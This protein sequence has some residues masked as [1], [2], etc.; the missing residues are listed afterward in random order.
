[1]NKPGAPRKPA[2]LKRVQ[3]C[4]TVAGGTDKLLREHPEGMGRAI[5][6]L[7]KFRQSKE[8]E[9]YVNSLLALPEDKPKPVIKF[10]GVDIDA[11]HKR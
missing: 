11:I 6:E 5:D 3:I 1:M 8:V 9:D 4:T 7:A 10:G 2:E